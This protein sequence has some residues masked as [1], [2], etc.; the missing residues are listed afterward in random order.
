MPFAVNVSNSSGNTVAT[1][2]FTGAGLTGG[3]IG[4]G[5]YTL[6][7]LSA[8]VTINGQA[9]RGSSLLMTKSLEEY[10]ATFKAPIWGG[11]LSYRVHVDTKIGIRDL[12]TR[13]STGPRTSAHGE[14]PGRSG[15]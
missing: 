10:I 14:S 8:Q 2:T 12:P 4:D 7:V 6:T 13:D 15:S 1:I 5:N 11:P 3:S 9:A